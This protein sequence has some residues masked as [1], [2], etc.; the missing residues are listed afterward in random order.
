MTPPLPPSRRRRLASLT[1]AIGLVAVLPVV[2]AASSSVAAP[3]EDCVAP[4]PLA[5]VA[6]DME[7][8]G[9]TVSR[10]TEPDPF[11]GTVLGVLTNGIAPGVDMIIADLDSPAIAAAG[12]I[13]QGM[14]GSPVYAE[15]GRLLGAVSYGLSYGPSPI[16]GIT[17]FEA[18][19]DYLPSARATLSPALAAEVATRADVSTRAAGRG[20]SQLQVPLGVAGVSPQLLSR[21]AQEAEGHSWF[22][23]GAMVMGRAA[24]APVGPTADDV[25]AGGNLAASL[26]YGDVALAGVGTA[27]SVCDGEVV[28]FGHPLDFAGDDQTYGLHPAEAVYVQ[29]DS[30]GAP[31]KIA[32]LGDPVGTITDD[33]LTGIT[34][35][36][37]DVPD[38]ITVQSDVTYGARRRLGTSYVS[39]PEALAEV[40]FYQ[41]LGNHLTVVD[42]ES[43]GS[44]TQT[45]TIE[46]FDT[47]GS[48]FTFTHSSL[49]AS[50]D[51]LLYASAFALPDL[52]D[53]ISSI[54]G[55]RITSVLNEVVVNPD[56]QFL[57]IGKVQQ[58]RAA[59]W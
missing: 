45:W 57:K 12:G 22:S 50:E 23:G 21:A 31:F 46:G 13:W 6:A 58:F 10:G 5:E 17:P 48:P 18:M 37:G 26:S 15:D 36:F 53:E 9:L 32:N 51:D 35:S 52:L 8:D 29:P 7:V 1:A 33:H 42:E 28:G 27:T 3:V 38:V 59:S 19:D 4:F 14:S 34:G 2:G 43:G 47:D 16:A 49:F 56:A 40:A 39:V 55:V 30:L 25:E 24:A 20:L 44:E 11:T 54:E 41:N